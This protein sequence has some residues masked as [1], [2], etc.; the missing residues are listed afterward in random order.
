MDENLV[1]WTMDLLTG[2]RN[3]W[4]VELFLSGVLIF[5]YEDKED[6]GI[7]RFMSLHLKL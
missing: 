6:L 7:S 1:G 2:G 3:T 4:R 5:L